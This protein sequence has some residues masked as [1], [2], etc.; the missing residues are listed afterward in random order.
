[1]KNST[2]FAI[3]NASDCRSS[4]VQAEENKS[5][6]IFKKAKKNK[7]TKSC[8][9]HT[10]FSHRFIKKSVLALCLL[11]N[12]CF[13]FYWCSQ[14]QGW[15]LD[16]AFSYAQSNYISSSEDVWKDIPDFDS[17]KVCQSHDG[18]KDFLTVQPDERFS[19]QKLQNNLIA[20]PPLFYII[21]HS[22][23]SFFP[24]IFSKWIGLWFNL[25]IFAFT[26]MIFYALACRFLSNK[27][28]LLPVVLY[29]FSVAAICS[30]VFVRSYMLFVFETVLLCLIALEFL[31][32]QKKHRPLKKLLFA[33]CLT[34]FCGCITHYYFI[35]TAFVLCAGMCVILLMRKA[36][37]TL[38]VFSIS[39][40]LTVFLC[41]CLFPVMIKHL[42]YYERSIE[43]SVLPMLNRNISDGNFSLSVWNNFINTDF[44]AHVFPHGFNWSLW[45]LVA[46]LIW[47]FICI[48]R[49][50][51]NSEIALLSAVLVFSVL[52]ISAIMPLDV[53][54]YFFHLAPIFVLLLF[55]AVDQITKK[56]KFSVI[57]QSVL[58]FVCLYFDLKSPNF[59]H[60]LYNRNTLQGSYAQSLQNKTLYIKWIHSAH[61]WRMNIPALYSFSAAKH[62]VFDNFDNECYQKL[63]ADKKALKNA[64]LMAA[65]YID[66]VGCENIKGWFLYFTDGIACAYLPEQQG[67]TSEE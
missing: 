2:V 41:P 16:E 19:L 39:T 32:N 46:A 63:M 58:V 56:L 11:I 48:V 44:F 52:I 59:E 40:I 47:G 64:A 17:D 21:F 18:I 31:A 29:G 6:N 55:L 25:F 66:E 1:M 61:R 8:F 36:Y 60:Y 13:M 7:Q 43:S 54:R 35:I 67:E 37:Q 12:L 26:Q 34:L 49:K 9:K 53:K 5:Q 50:K 33:F 24:N 10:F 30:V 22:I 15:F 42:F 45:A 14:K 23:H 27:K 4:G 28:A 62:I 20:H 65:Y 57:W 38:T 51:I 3:L